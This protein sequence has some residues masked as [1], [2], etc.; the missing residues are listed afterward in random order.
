MID[1]MGS[2][3]RKAHLRG[4]AATEF[5]VMLTIMVPMFLS[6]PVLGK[7]INYKHKTIES[8]RYAVWERTV[9]GAPQ[10]SWNE[11]EVVKTDKELSNE[12]DLRFYGDSSQRM[13]DKK[14]TSNKLWS[15][16]SGRSLIKPV[17]DSNQRIVVDEKHVV[18]P[19]KNHF[20]N[21]IA[22]AGAPL[23]GNAAGALSDAA[24]STV[25][26]IIHDCNNIPGINFKNGM[27]LG[28]RTYSVIQVKSTVGKSPLVNKDLEFSSNGTILTNA[29]TAPN[30]KS[31]TSRIGAL[32]AEETVRCITA[33]SRVISLFP[34]YL[35][36][37][38]A[39]KISAT[40]KSTV[41]P[42]VYKRK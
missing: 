23:I 24:S 33:P 31:Y 29:W 14:S 13:A 6:I 18:S 41:L 12:I 19:I 28:S 4:V 40:A 3:F 15:D 7:Y 20:V 30:E 16:F 35:E 36:G 9:W 37:R 10:G 39:T 11:K 22:Y 34:L 26:N 17:P 2:I 8:S 38:K 21:E 25:G 27:N 5:A 32:V 42:S 1:H